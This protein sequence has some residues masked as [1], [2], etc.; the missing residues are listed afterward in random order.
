MLSSD[1]AV[2]VAG[3]A[4]AVFFTATV[5]SMYALDAQLD[6]DG[7]PSQRKKRRKEVDGRTVSSIWI[8]HVTQRARARAFH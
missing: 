2:A 6:K 4:T 3:A 8:M 1:G 5:Y 7:Q